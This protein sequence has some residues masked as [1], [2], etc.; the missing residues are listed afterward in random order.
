MRGICAERNILVAIP[1]DANSNCGIRTEQDVLPVRPAAVVDYFN[2]I[3]SRHIAE[4]NAEEL[5]DLSLVRSELQKV[6]MDLS[7]EDLGK[8]HVSF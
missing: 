5:P 6:S 4:T 2:Q 1:C 8:E 7:F 3:S